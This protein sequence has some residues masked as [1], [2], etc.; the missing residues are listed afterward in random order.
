MFSKQ[1]ARIAEQKK[2]LE[3]VEDEDIVE[4]LIQDAQKS[5]ERRQ[6]RQESLGLEEVE[7]YPFAPQLSVTNKQ[8]SAS[9]NYPD[10]YQSFMQRQQAHIERAQSKQ[11]SL[12]SI[13]EADPHCTFRPAIDKNSE[14]IVESMPQRVGESAEARF[15]RMSKEEHARREHTKA[16]IEANFYAKLKFEPKINPISRDLGRSSS[17]SELAYNQATRSD[18]KLQAEAEAA[19]EEHHYSFQP[20]LIAS[21]KYAR[22]ESDYRQ[23]DEILKAIEQRQLEKE[24]KLLQLKKE[25]DYAEL[26]DCVFRPQV[27]DL[28]SSPVSNGAVVVNGFARYM[29]LRDLAK[30]KEEQRQEREDKVFMT[31]VKHDPYHLYTV[32]QP[33]QLQPSKKEQKVA[34]LKQ[35]LQDKERAQCTFQPQTL[36]YKN[37]ELIGR[38]LQQQSP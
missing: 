1:S 6:R 3:E 19:M 15:N 20:R 29:E 23:G 35:E 14:C 13:S 33:F 17:L 31:N 12:L 28:K 9:L 4:R 25:K 38:L 2:K 26:K 22:V 24:E 30:R 16:Q 5:I 32:P 8:G 10:A 36:E 18:K 21:K 37:R 34:K 7:K 11:K 27:S